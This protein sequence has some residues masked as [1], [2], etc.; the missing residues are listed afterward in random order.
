[1]HVYGREYC[2]HTRKF[3]HKNGNRA[4]KSQV[5]VFVRIVN[6][7]VTENNISN[8][9]TLI[10]NEKN[11][12]SGVKLQKNNKQTLFFDS[13]STQLYITLSFSKI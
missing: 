8:C 6:I 3:A 2:Q 10:L 4:L 1:M 9:L 5:S 12:N 13:T 11:V 7:K